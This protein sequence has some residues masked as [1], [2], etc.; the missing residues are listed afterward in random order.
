MTLKVGKSATSVTL[1]VDTKGGKFIASGSIG[2]DQYIYI[3]DI[4]T[5]MYAF[6]TH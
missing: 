3:Y 4:S 1:S 5:Y 6:M 2:L